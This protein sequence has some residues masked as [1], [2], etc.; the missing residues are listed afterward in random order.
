MVII[1]LAKCFKHFFFN[2]TAAVPSKV[3][4]R[5]AGDNASRNNIPSAAVD[6]ESEHKEENNGDKDDNQQIMGMLFGT[7]L[8]QDWNKI[9]NFVSFSES[10]F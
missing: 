6:K 4:S 10:Y 1:I 5:L 7:K 8:M 3:E 9:C 2:H